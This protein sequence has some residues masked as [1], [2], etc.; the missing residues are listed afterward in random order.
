MDLLQRLS[1]VM[2]VSPPSTLNGP[3][4]H[5]RTAAC[6]MLAR[7]RQLHHWAVHLAD[8][9]PAQARHV[10]C[11]SQVAGSCRAIPH[12]GPCD[13]LHRFRRHGSQLC[14]YRQERRASASPPPPRNG[15]S[16]A[17]P[18]IASFAQDCEFHIF[19]ILSGAPR[20]AAGFF[21]VAERA[22]A[23]DSLPAAG[24]VGLPHP[25]HCGLRHFF[26]QRGNS[27]TL[28]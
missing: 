22:A 10:P 21:C 25:N 26:P 23:W 5:S 17:I 11:F 19:S 9:H 27:Q 12:T 3:A 20:T 8:G 6:V 1:K 15:C 14:A 13:S 7:S 16:L 2:I 18:Y 28:S 4:C 24:C